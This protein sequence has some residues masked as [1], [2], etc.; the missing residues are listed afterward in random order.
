MA[1]PKR[2]ASPRPKQA[3]PNRQ[4]R[5]PAAEPS[6]LSQRVSR[7]SSAQTLERIERVRATHQQTEAELTALVDHA[8]GLGIGWPEIATRLGVTRQGA[9][10]QYQR[11][12][13]D[14]ASRQDRPA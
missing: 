11:R 8:V 2:Q 10:Q 12:H 6:G 3:Q 14:D 4:R 13:R 1:R 7:L 5:A 9:R